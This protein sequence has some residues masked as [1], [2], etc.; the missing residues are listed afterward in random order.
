[1]QKLLEAVVEYPLALVAPNE[2]FPRAHMSGIA[3]GE[4]ARSNAA[5]WNAYEIWHS[6]IRLSPGV[7]SLFQPRR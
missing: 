2:E 3:I 6:R 7:T 4:H 1:M 5:G